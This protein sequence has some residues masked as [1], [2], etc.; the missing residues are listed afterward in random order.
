MELCFLR[1]YQEDEDDNVSDSAVSEEVIVSCLLIAAVSSIMD[2]EQFHAMAK[3]QQNPSREV[4]CCRSA[5]ILAP[6]S[7]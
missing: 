3:S 4:D 6:E 2:S 5:G 7:G 1:M